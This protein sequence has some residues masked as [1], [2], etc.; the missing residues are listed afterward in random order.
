MGGHFQIETESGD[1][2]STILSSFLSSGPF[3]AWDLSNY[4]LFLIISRR[5]SQIFITFNLARKCV[6]WAGRIYRQTF[7]QTFIK[8]SSTEISQ[9]AEKYC[10]RSEDN[11]GSW[12]PSWFSTQCVPYR[13]GIR[14][15]L[16]K[17]TVHSVKFCARF[18]ARWASKCHCRAHVFQRFA[19]LVNT[20]LTCLLNHYKWGIIGCK[21]GS[22]VFQNLPGRGCWSCSQLCN[23]PFCVLCN[24]NLG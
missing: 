2:V 14:E 21:N 4:V 1:K 15:F 10:L 18:L 6:L 9:K 5:K 3:D 16:E 8:T 12:L 13:S 23:S 19:P 24:A 7:H 20:N 11:D 22:L 17:M